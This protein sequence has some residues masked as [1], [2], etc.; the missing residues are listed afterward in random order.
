MGAQWRTESLAK[1]L[2]G[3]LAVTQREGL[4]GLSAGLISRVL[5]VG[6]HAGD[7]SLCLSV[8]SPPCQ[9]LTYRGMLAD[10]SCGRYCEEVS[11]VAMGRQR[12][13]HSD[14]GL[15]VLGVKSE[16]Q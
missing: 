9:F 5:W 16:S 7:L 13:D 2:Q 3:L 6:S 15:D 12:C 10:P 11:V 8:P 1:Q 4:T 14:G